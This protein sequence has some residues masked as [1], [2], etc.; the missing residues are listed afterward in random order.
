M[1]ETLPITSIRIGDRH[2]KELHNIEDLAQSIADVGLLHPVVVTPDGELVAGQRRLAAVTKLGWASVPVTVVDIDEILLGEY[3]ENTYREDFT[4]TEAVSIGRALENRL[5][6]PVGRP[7]AE[8]PVNYR[9][10]PGGDTRDK[11]G[12][13]VGMSGKTYEKAKRVVEA[14]EEDPETYGDLPQ[15]M[16][17]TNPTR[18]FREMRKRQKAEAPPMP[19]DKYR[20]LYADP[21]WFYAQVIEKYGPAERHYPTMKTPDICAMGDKVKA[22]TTDD[23]VLFLWSTSPK[24]KD[25]LDVAAAWGFRYTGAMFVWDKIKHNYGHYNSVRHELL[26]ICTRGSCT[27]DVAKL[28]DS[29]QT[30]ERTE[31]SEKPEEFR[32]IIDAIYTKGKRI[33]LFARRSAPGWDVWG[34]EV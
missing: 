11:V 4:P 28:Y 23:A 31:H 7:P 3:A 5:S 19:T 8:T 18:A 10:L 29:V 16:D 21:P 1:T 17:E 33:E 30:I 25:A 34:N 22:I 26:L 14:A 9:S 6:T 12:E 20:V 32:T 27:P 24:L 15:A 13:A 2:R